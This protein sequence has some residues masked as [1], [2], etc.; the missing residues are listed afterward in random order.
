MLGVTVA[1]TSPEALGEAH[2]RAPDLVLVDA[3]LPGDHGFRLAREL[4]ELPNGGGMPI[5]FLSSDT[6]FDRRVEAAHAGASLFLEKPLDESSIASALSQLLAQR[7]VRPR[8]LIVDDDPDFRAKTSSILARSGM[9][10]RSTDDARDLLEILDHVRPDLLLLDVQLPG[11]SGFD[12][13]RMIR[14]STTWRSLPVLFITGRTSI[15][16]RVAAFQAGGDDY[17]AKPVVQEELLA[18][19]NVRLERTRLMKERAEKDALTGIATRRSFFEQFSAND[20]RGHL[21]GDRVLATLGKLLSARF[22]AADI[23]GRWGGEEFSLAFPDESIETAAGVVTRLLEELRAMPFE[24]E[25]GERFTVSFSAGLSTF[26][27]DGATFQALARTAD[28]RLYAAK[29]AGRG[30]V[31]STGS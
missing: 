14:T 28:L 3:D 10:V 24:G 18:R 13:C 16:S 11:V 29:R 31:I 12:V 20:E 21:V 27:V 30:R 9:D 15:E 19:L 22:R 1:A 25:D 8:I 5:A 2:R 17:L 26:P 23:R 4:R 6:S 7:P